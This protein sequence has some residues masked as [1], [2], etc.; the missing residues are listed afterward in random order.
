[1]NF[2]EFGVTSSIEWQDIQTVYVKADSSH[3]SIKYL[4]TLT[5]E[6]DINKPYADFKFRTAIP[7]CCM[8]NNVEILEATQEIGFIVEFSKEEQ[9]FDWLEW[10][11]VRMNGKIIGSIGRNINVENTYYFSAHEGTNYGRLMTN[12]K[13]SGNY[14][15]LDEAKDSAYLYAEYLNKK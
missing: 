5:D 15:T 7:E 12:N 8:L 4:L 2:Y 11:T 10:H 1:M 9:D 13:Y 6:D 14:K 3:D